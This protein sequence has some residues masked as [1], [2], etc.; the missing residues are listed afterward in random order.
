MSEVRF[1][2]V[3]CGKATDT[4]NRLFD[5]DPDC[6]P[7]CEDCRA[8][9]EQETMRRFSMWPKN[10]FGHWM[11]T[12]AKWERNYYYSGQTNLHAIHNQERREP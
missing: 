12:G 2:C 5:C 6:A 11:W 3:R 9:V 4:D 1:N 8:E 10:W 7:A